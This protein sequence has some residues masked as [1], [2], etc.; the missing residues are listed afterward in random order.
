MKPNPTRTAQQRLAN[1]ARDRRRKWLDSW[2]GVLCLLVAGL[3]VSIL[4]VLILAIC[5]KGGMWINWNFL[6]AGHLENQPLQSGIGPA[7]VGSLLICLICGLVAMP[8]GVGTAVF[9]EEFPP[10]SRTIRFLHHLVQLNISNL[11]GVPSIVYGILGVTAFVYMFGIFGKIET[12]RA[13]RFELGA[14]YRYQTKTLAGTWVSFPADDPSKSFATV[15]RP[16]SVVLP[17]GSWGELNVLDAAAAVPSDPELLARTVRAGNPASLTRVQHPWYLHLPLHKSIL[18]AGLTLALVIMPIIIIASQESLRAVPGS[19][20][21]AA[22]GLGAT[23]WQVVRRSV[24]P[25]ALP[26]IMT[27]AILAV[28]RALGEAAP[29]L[30]VMGAVVSTSGLTSLMDKTPT[31]PGIIYRWSHDENHF[32][33]NSA[34]A[35][36]IVLLVLL[37]FINSAAI[38]I[39][40]RA[41][42]LRGQN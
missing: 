4:A 35:A 42:K 12:G 31:L 13:P 10:R 16:R 23:R 33:E 9:L 37:L 39:R 6:T 14:G 19:I 29:L 2:F 38:L 24:I 22:F 36:I 17:D 26:G 40:Y 32:F 7:I 8:I 3:S 27:G 5:G 21:E 20:R 1:P 15:D 34:A 41:E 11:A 28:S 30:A 25:A 18:A